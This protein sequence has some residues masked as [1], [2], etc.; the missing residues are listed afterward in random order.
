MYLLGAI[1]A[2]TIATTFL[3]KT[4]QFTKLGPSLVT[5]L[6]YC[7]AFYLLSHTLKAIPVGV[8]YGLWSAIG[9]VLI[10]IVSAILFK[11]IPDLPAIIGIILII[12]GVVCIQMLS[13]MEA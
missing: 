13:K 5:I 11:Q 8:A 4:E 10:V 9:I 2:E 3:K 7:I 12:A 1:L 6:G